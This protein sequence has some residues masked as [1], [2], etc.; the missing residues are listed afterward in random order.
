VRDFGIPYVG[1]EGFIASLAQLRPEKAQAT[2]VRAFYELMRRLREVHDVKL[3]Q[4]GG[5]RPTDME[6]VEGL[7]KLLFELNWKMGTHL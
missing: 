4:I 6:R 1:Q 3:I 5:T 7:N 2:Q